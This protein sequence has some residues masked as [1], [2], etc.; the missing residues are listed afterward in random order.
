M[1]S[2]LPFRAGPVAVQSSAGNLLNP[3]T[4][5]GGINCTSIYSKLNILL[6]HIR[7]VNVTGSNATIT[8][9]IGASGASAAGTEFAWCATVVPANSYLDWYGYCPL[10][11]TDFLTGIAGT[12]S[13]LTITFE[14][15][16]SVAKAA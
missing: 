16:I 14:G 15:E 12:A 2:N 10:S 5:T 11:S 3:G 9:Y 13:A 6:R 8:L 7:V 4:T 1:P